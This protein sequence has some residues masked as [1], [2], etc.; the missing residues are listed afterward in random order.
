M[1]SR[2]QQPKKPELLPQLIGLIR[3]EGLSDYTSLLEGR[4]IK[5]GDEIAIPLVQGSQE[6]VRK[7]RLLPDGMLDGGLFGKEKSKKLLQGAVWY[8]SQ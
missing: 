2:F 1:N 6:V 5:P 7:Y 4:L 8:F 3:H